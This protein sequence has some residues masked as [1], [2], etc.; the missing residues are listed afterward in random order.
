MGILKRNN[1]SNQSMQLIDPIPNEPEPDN[2]PLHLDLSPSFAPVP[3]HHPCKIDE[4]LFL[5]R[6]A[7][8]LDCAQ[9][10]VWIVLIVLI[11]MMIE[12]LLM[13]QL[14]EGNWIHDHL[15]LY[16]SMLNHFHL[17]LHFQLQYLDL[18][19]KRKQSLN[20]LE[21]DLVGHLHSMNLMEERD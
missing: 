16:H 7:Q 3:P 11:V 4:S 12:C 6:N 18:V 9:R 8:C 5:I 17:D 13:V 2:A 15:I 14:V 10:Y 1:Q 19:M 20:H 21:L